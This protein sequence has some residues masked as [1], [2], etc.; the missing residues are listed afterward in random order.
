MNQISHHPLPSMGILSFRGPDALRFLQS[1]L[2][3]DVA[4]LA[5]GIAKPAAW[6]SPQGRVLAVLWLLATSDGALAVLPRSLAPATAEGLGRFVLRARLKVTDESA[7][8]AV[9][10]FVGELPSVAEGASIGRLPADRALLVGP[11]QALAAAAGRRPPGDEN[12]WW[13]RCL[14]QGEP[15]VF[16]ATRGEWIPQMLNL[17]LIG[18]V[19]FS[20]GCYS[21]QE[22]VARAHH[23]GRV[24]RRMARYECVA[25]AL[26][27]PGHGLFDGAEK[28]AEVVAAAPGAP[29]QLLAVVNLDS[30][31]RP[32]GDA[33]GTLALRPLPLPYRL[34][35]ASPPA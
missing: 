7:R 34:P 4:A 25:G 19:S 26:P 31:G 5:D 35:E 23:L 2:T 6:C 3:A 10:G 27:E 17:D 32:L 22:I 1:Q 20:K 13:A 18:A 14:A 11:P 8:L 21:G 15:M 30:L 28:V 33:P 24:K 16:P 29:A 12:A 9:A